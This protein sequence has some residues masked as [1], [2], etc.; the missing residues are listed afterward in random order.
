M[1]DPFFFLTFFAPAFAV[2]V[3]GA[4]NVFI[5]D[6]ATGN[7]SVVENLTAVVSR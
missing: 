3:V 7:V 4:V 6:A 2:I 1:P 5:P